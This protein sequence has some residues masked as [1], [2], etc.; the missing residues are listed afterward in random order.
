VE[1][2]LFRVECEDGANVR[3]H[4]NE[5]VAMADELIYHAKDFSWTI[6]EKTKVSTIINSLPKSYKFVEDFY[7]LAES[8]WTIDNLITSRKSRR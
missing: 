3:K 4:V 6:D 5:M 7:T 8:E 1:E 2:I